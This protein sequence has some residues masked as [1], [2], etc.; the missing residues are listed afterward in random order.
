MPVAAF[1]YYHPAVTQTTSLITFDGRASH[2]PDNG[3]VRCRWDFDNEA[4]DPD[5]SIV[6]GVWA[7]LKQEEQNGELVWVWKDKFNMQRI[8]YTFPGAKKEA[9]RY[10]V[11]LTVWDYDGNEDSVTHEVI[12]EK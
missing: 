5:G 7:T 1:F 6:E 10:T 12:V 4:K 3:I 11:T 2:D 8:S 9:K